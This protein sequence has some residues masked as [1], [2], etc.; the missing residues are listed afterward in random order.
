MQKKDK[1]NTFKL[2]CSNCKYKGN[3]LYFSFSFQYM[4]EKYSIDKCSNEQKLSFINKVSKLSLLTWGQIINSPKH[5]LGTEKI[6]QNCIVG[7]TI[8][9]I[10]KE[11]RTLLAIKFHNKSPMVGFRDRDIFYVIWFDRDFTLYNHGS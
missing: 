5:G 1:D 7:D 10:I 4:S 9:K 8:P 2:N 6:E 3:H 11:D